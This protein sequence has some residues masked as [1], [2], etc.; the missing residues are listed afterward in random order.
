MIRCSCKRHDGPVKA[1]VARQINRQRFCFNPSPS[2]EEQPQCGSKSCLS[3]YFNPRPSHEGRRGLVEVAL[4]LR[5]VSIH[6]PRMRGDRTAHSPINAHRGFNPCP[7]HEG[8]QAFATS[9]VRPTPVSIHAPRMRGDFSSRLLTSTA[10][11]FN[12][13]PSH[14][15]RRQRGQSPRTRWSF[16]P[17]P[18]HEGRQNLAV[19]SALLRRFQSTPLA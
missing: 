2:H 14:E 17:R 9:T 12:P 19:D 1:A 13:R 10:T 5:P 16:N 7:S 4:E 6:A 3:S 18:S 11:S 8:R 15:G